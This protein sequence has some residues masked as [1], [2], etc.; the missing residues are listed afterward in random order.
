MSNSESPI[1]ST[2]FAASSTLI[3]PCSWCAA[4]VA[5][6]RRPGRPRLYCNQAC[7]Q[8]AYEH[9]H[10]L[11][12]RRTERELPGQ[13]P[14]AQPLVGTGTSGYERGGFLSLL[15]RRRHAM[16]P[17]VRPDGNRRETMCGL[18]VPLQVGK[19]FDS[20]DPGSCLTCKTIVSKR[21]L[22]FPIHPSNDLA[23]LRSVID[24][25]VE[26]RLEPAAALQWLW[27]NAPGRRMAA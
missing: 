11:R 7:R 13:D 6:H 15:G 18:I 10:G 9:R 22:Q 5:Q 3:R 21:P 26:H 17:S 12:H 2:V 1:A 25:A 16:R 19:S 27:A 8:R 23:R 24:E 14:L 4:E 20:A